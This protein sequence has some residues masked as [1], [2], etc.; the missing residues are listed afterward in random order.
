MRSEGDGPLTA[1]IVRTILDEVKDPEVPVVSVLELGIV[2]DVRIEGSRVAITITPTYS[3]C[4]AMREIEQD[5]RTALRAEGIDDVALETVYGLDWSRCPRETACVRNCAT[6]ARGT[7]RS[8]DTRAP[9]RRR[10]VPTLRIARHGA[11]VR[12]RLDRLQGDSRLQCVPGAV[13][14]IQGVL[15]ALAG[16]V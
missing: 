1:E 13:R 12:V 5:I 14:R 6:R 15:D 9:P 10:R 4:P 16:A 7:W 11:S 2:R 8:R 3:G